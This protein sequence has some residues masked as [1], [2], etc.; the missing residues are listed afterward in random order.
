M[1][2]TRCLVIVPDSMLVLIDNSS[3]VCTS[4]SDMIFVRI[5]LVSFAT[6][7]SRKNQNYNV[8]LSLSTATATS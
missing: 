2:E 3:S 1:V 8:Q 6:A 7:R 5:N 4:E